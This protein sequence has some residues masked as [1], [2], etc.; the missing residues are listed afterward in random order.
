MLKRLPSPALIVACLALV[1]ALGGVSYAAGVLPANSVGAKQLRSSAVTPSKISPKTLALLKGQQG[2]TGATAA[3]ARGSLFA[4]VPEGGVLK[5]GT[6]T[7]SRRASLGSYVVSF[8]RDVT[9]CAAVTSAGPTDG[10]FTKL[11]ADGVTRIAAGAA[12]EVTVDFYS[13]DSTSAA[14][15]TDTDFHLIVAC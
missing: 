7:G 9:S 6:A 14:A 10:G 15:P 13:P 4:N 8:A 12:N 2:R 1:V 3:A 11:N 5:S